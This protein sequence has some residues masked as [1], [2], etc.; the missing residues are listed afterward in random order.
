MIEKGKNKSLK[1]IYLFFI[2]IIVFLA[3][4]VLDSL[5][6][7]YFARGK[8]VIGGYYDSEIYVDDDYMFQEYNAYYKYHYR[9][10]EDNKFYKLYNKVSSENIEEIKM[11]YNDFKSKI[12]FKE[13]IKEVDFK[14]DNIKEG[15]Y[16]LI[17]DYNNMNTRVYYEKFHH[18][19][20]YYYDIKTHILYVLH[21]S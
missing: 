16:F 18:Y 13:R 5:L 19:N 15:D 10:K 11:Y 21:T 14:E 8:Y 2:I 9:Q 6:I 12:D 4:F 7:G 1:I 3:R 20:V 17:R